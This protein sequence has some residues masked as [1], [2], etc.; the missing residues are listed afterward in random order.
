MRIVDIVRSARNIDWILIV[1][2]LILSAVGLA[3]I[4]SVDLSRGDTLVLF[5]VQVFACC[6]GLAVLAIGT[7]IHVTVYRSAA[8][9]AYLFG[10]LLLVG[11]LFFGV[12]VRGTT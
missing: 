10:L 4:Y 8:G 1:V 11:V 6:L 12:T 3:A 5:P 7:Y 9:L 2:V